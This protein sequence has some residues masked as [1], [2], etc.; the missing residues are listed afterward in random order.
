MPLSKQ[1][2]QKPNG[3]KGRVNYPPF[4]LWRDMLC[5]ICK[6]DISEPICQYGSPV[7]ICEKC[8]LDGFS[9]VVDDPYLLR[10]IQQGFTIEQAI[11]KYHHEEVGKSVP[12][13]QQ[14]R[15]HD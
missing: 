12:E 14:W 13:S 1:R 6:T 8:F 9:W 5:P 4:T 11:E 15:L 7:A 10:H 3:V 2:L